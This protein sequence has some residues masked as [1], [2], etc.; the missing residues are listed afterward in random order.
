MLVINPHVLNAAW[1][2]WECH[3]YLL[4]CY[5]N[6]SPPTSS[7][8]TLPTMLSPLWCT[9]Q[10]ISPLIFFHLNVDHAVIL[11]WQWLSTKSCVGGKDCLFSFSWPACGFQSCQEKNPYSVEEVSCTC[12][13]NACISLF[14]AHT[15]QARSCVDIFLSQS[16]N[17][18]MLLLHRNGFLRHD[19][20]LCKHVALGFLNIGFCLQYALQ[21]HPWLCLHCTNHSEGIASTA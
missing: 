11:D 14:P 17:Q 4:S 6:P 2:F 21:K 13:A 7:P 18:Y 16:P 19:A 1:R 15:K 20:K 8:D 5:C 10:P 12:G 3:V 9:Y